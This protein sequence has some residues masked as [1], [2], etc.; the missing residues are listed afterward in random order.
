MSDPLYARNLRQN[1]RR[2]KEKFRRKIESPTETPTRKRPP[3]FNSLQNFFQWAPTVSDRFSDGRGPSEF[4]TVIMQCVVDF[5]REDGNSVGNRNFRWNSQ[6]SSK[7]KFGPRNK[8]LVASLQKKFWLQK[9]NIN[10][11][12][13]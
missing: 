13:I 2:K 3:G 12:H 4:P 5:L 8:K 6:L 10:K 7:K 1:L 11:Q 9:K